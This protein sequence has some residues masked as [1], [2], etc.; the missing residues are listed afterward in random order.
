[1]Q[2]VCREPKSV[3]GD[4]ISNVTEIFNGSALDRDC[5]D[6]RAGVIGGTDRAFVESDGGEP[7]RKNPRHG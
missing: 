4:R 5:G 1:M 7:R 3:R 6:K 2:L